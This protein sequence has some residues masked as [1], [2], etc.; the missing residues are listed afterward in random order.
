MK[1]N[2]SQ[3]VR[4]DLIDFDKYLKA[5]SDAAKVKPVSEWEQELI[6]SFYNPGPTL[7]VTLPWSK[8]HK[9]V[10]LRPQEL[11][12]WCGYNGSG[13]SL[14]LNQVIAG[15][16]SQG[17]KACIASLEMPVVKTLKRFARQ[18]SGAE[19]PAIPFLKRIVQWS[20]GKLWMYDQLGT[21][22]SSRMIAV[23]RY[24][25]EE[26]GVT[27]MVIDSMMKCGLQIAG[28]SA[29]NSEKKFIDELCALA[30]ESN[31]HI[32]LVTHSRKTDSE[33]QRVDKM[34]VKGAGEIT[35]QAD[36][37]FMVWRNKP[38]EAQRDEGEHNGE[39]DMLLTC[40]KQRHGEWEGK[41]AL[42]YDKKSMQYVGFENA[43]AIDF[44][45]NEQEAA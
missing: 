24:C 11:S 40:S 8:T 12:I 14:L 33:F 37:V 27:H 7:G 3:Y 42:W 30:K 32:H 41:I 44:M 23:A 19:E 35:D 13:K 43:R 2:T 38:K 31:L 5:P 29:R 16:L 17:E 9:D 4:D 45:T 22:E 20:L 18:L 39:P 21:V 34:D 15:V 28:D 25:A 6:D 26:L 36:N 1:L 10:R